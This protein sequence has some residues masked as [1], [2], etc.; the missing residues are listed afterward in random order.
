MSEAVAMKLPQRAHRPQQLAP[1]R[2]SGRMAAL[3]RRTERTAAA[4]QS[5]VGTLR[6]AAPPAG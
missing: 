5:A 2:G 1:V 4:V 3:R 6:G